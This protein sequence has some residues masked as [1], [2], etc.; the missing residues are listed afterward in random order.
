MLDQGRSRC[1]R[2]RVI[3]RQAIV[4]PKDPSTN[5]LDARVLVADDNADTREYLP[6]F[7]LKDELV[8]KQLGAR[9]RQGVLEHI[10]EHDR[11]FE[12]R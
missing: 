5:A 1:D 11:L 12:P 2:C 9:T 3:G 6:R 8:R 10:D 4:A 7:G